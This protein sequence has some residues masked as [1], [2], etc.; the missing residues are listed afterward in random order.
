MH[1]KFRNIN[2]A[3]RELVSGIHS[4]TI[5]TTRRS[6]RNGD[7]LM[8]EEPCVITYTHPRERV[9]FNSARDA[10]PFFALYES[11]WMIAGRN[12]VQSLAYYVKDIGKYS[13]DGKTFNGAYGYRW[14]HAKL[15]PR[16]NDQLKRLIDHLKRTPDSRRAVLSMWNVEDDL[17]KIDSSRDVCCNLSVCFSIRTWY[18]SEGHDASGEPPHR[19][20]DMTVFNR[21]NDMIL[22]MLGA[23]VVHFSILQEYMAAHLGVEVGVYNQ[24]TNNLHCYVSNWEPERW[25]GD[26]LPDFYERYPNMRDGEPYNPE[27]CYSWHKPKLLSLVSDP[28]TFDRELP[29]FVELHKGP[30]E[31]TCKIAWQEPFFRDVASPMLRAFHVYKRKDY[32]AAL[33]WAGRIEADDWRI[34]ARSWI[35]RRVKAKEAKHGSK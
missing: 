23:N 11:M 31:P 1:L 14:R 7:V 28:A 15:Y 32:E 21:S 26:V 35:E 5:P 12:D 30:E 34:A 13:D 18:E 20:L 10:N 16:H 4:N 22:G 8:I 29:E 6:S 19:A 25:L 27:W 3:F 9:L 24:V 17:L 2:Q 33:V